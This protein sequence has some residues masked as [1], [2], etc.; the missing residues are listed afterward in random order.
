MTDGM[1]TT[2]TI[3]E[4][5][6]QPYVGIRR[7]VT[8]TSLD[9]VADSLPVVFGWLGRRGLA[10]A[11]AAFFK[12]NVIDMERE[13]IVEA[14]VPVPSVQP[15]GDDDVLSGVLP[16]GRF[17]TV[18]HTGHPDEL[19][20]V[21]ADLLGWADGQGLT[22]DRHDSPAGDVWACRL[23]V[24]LTDPA[25]GPDTNKWETQLLFKLAD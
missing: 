25:E 13:L 5:T 15:G 11:G 7:T 14:G 8:M 9:Q 16:A 1:T 17:A 18:T 24:Y 22:F 21:T 19:L 20:Q 4:R 23:E 2:P 12:F 3:V 6:V 10:P